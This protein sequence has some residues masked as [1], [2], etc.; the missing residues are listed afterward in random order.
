MFRF[1]TAG[2]SHGK[3]LTGVIE[4]LPSGLVVDTDFINQQLHRRQLGH[5]RGRRM[6]IEKDRIDITAGVRHGRTLGGPVAFLIENKDWNNWR[7]PMSPEPV[8]EEANLRSLTRPRPGH[9]DLAGVL[10]HQTHDARDVLERA[11]ARET[12]ARVAVGAFC[13]LLLRR[14]GTHIASHV[15]AIG[16]V[17]VPQAAENV[18]SQEILALDAESPIRC[19]DA[20][21]EKE[22]MSR[23]DQAAKDGDTLGGVAEVIA[24]CVPAG[25]G[26]HTQWDRKIDGRLA[27]A[28]MS[29]PAVKAVEIGDGIGAANR[30]GSQVHDEIFYDLEQHRFFRKSNNAGG[31]E[32]GITNGA[33]LRARIFVKPIP[34]LRKALMSVDLI[35][36]EPS[37]A[38]FERS[39]TCVVPAAGV[40]A[41]AVMG[42]VLA[43][44]FLEKFG[45]DSMAEL[46]A[47]FANYQKQLSQF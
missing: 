18:N 23:I 1:V 35:T 3:C 4:G 47:A 6:Q 25:L 34:T 44:A 14:F 45:G 36:K 29:I 37:F 13:R 17:R 30:L 41:E 27:Q 10:K 38:G 21:I 39:D 16:G 11:S 46:E 28:L 42:I 20:D 32:G 9:V 43:A 26:S 8:A 12:A 22:M 40:V 2:E 15:L 33:D 19:A 31:V 24:A 5:G 7:I